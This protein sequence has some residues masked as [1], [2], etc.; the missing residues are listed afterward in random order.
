MLFLQPLLSVT[1]IL[2][3]WVPEN[4]RSGVWASERSKSMTVALSSSYP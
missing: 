3:V 1:F 4:A 2:N